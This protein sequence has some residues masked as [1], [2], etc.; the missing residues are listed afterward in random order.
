MDL[1]HETSREGSK[2]VSHDLCCH[3]AN[4]KPA[5]WTTDVS[6]RWGYKR[7]A[8]E[9]AR[10]Q[11]S[12]LVIARVCY[13]YIEQQLLLIWGR[14]LFRFYLMASRRNT[15]QG[16][17][18]IS[19]FSVQPVVWTTFTSCNSYFQ[20]QQ[21]EKTNFESRPQFSNDR[22]NNTLWR[23]SGVKSCQSNQ[24]QRCKRQT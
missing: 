1:G 11:A 18:E 4:L 2:I 12:A 16:D 21:I 7:H 19:Q 24:R 15:P 23:E 22:S 13:I 8:T 10:V 17:C 14:S 5:T 9:T 3:A 6:V 20:N